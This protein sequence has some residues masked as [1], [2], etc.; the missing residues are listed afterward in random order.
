VTI[1]GQEELRVVIRVE[2]GKMAGY[3]VESKDFCLLGPDQMV[4]VGCDRILEI[5]IERKL[6]RLRG[7]NSFSLAV[8]LWEGGLPVD[9]LPAEG[10]LEVE[11]GAD[12]FAWAPE[13]AK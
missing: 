10:W 11:L 4:K 12:H 3:I 2:L 6:L 1:R 7:R 13:P 9:L 5:S 8:A